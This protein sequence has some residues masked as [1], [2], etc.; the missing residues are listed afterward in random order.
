MYIY[1]FIWGFAGGISYVHNAEIT[2]IIE[3]LF[4][5]NFPKA[6]CIF[7][8]FINMDNPKTFLNWATKVPEFTYNK[9]VPFF[10]MLVA[11]IDTQKYSYLIEAMLDIEK[12]VI[13]TG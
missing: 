8:Y 6:D 13:L 7:D 3:D 1:S 10:Q 12:P 2:K 5:F 4:D 11:T 9:E